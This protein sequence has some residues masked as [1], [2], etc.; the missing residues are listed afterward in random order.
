MKVWSVSQAR[1][2]QWVA[3]PFSQ[4]S[5]QPGD[6]TRVSCI[7]SEF[8]MS[9]PINIGTYTFLFLAINLFRPRGFLTSPETDS[10]PVLMFLGYC[11][12]VSQTGWLIQQKCVVTF[13]ETRDMKSRCLLAR[14][15]PSE[16]CEEKICSKPS[17]WLFHR[18][19]RAFMVLSPC[20]SLSPNVPLL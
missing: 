2:L 6:Q 13:L 1:I 20:A 5:S 19:V 10:P 17:P 11:N 3:I 9:E 16:G 8:F 15:F 12:K 18:S 14:L 4:G 7:S